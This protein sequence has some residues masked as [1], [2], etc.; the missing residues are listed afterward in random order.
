ML[1]DFRDGLVGKDDLVPHASAPLRHDCLSGEG[2]YRGVLR[3]VLRQLEIAQG[4]VQRFIE[5]Q[6]IVGNRPRETHGTCLRDSADTLQNANAPVAALVPATGMILRQLE[7]A[8]NF[9]PV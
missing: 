4:D 5:D 9:A 3:L 2:F 6:L 1:L 8:G 7:I